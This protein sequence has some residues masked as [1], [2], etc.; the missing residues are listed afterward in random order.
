MNCVESSE[1]LYE[2]YS[3]NSSFFIANS[4]LNYMDELENKPMMDNAEQRVLWNLEAKLEPHLVEIVR[5]DYR[6]LVAK[7]K[8][9]VNN[10]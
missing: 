10:N 7:A 9:R 1:V 3:I 6:E 2:P 4:S 5:A 8:E